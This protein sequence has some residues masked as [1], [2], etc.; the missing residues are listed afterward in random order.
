MQQRL[1]DHGNPNSF[2]FPGRTAGVHFLVSLEVRSAHVTECLP[3]NDTGANVL[4]VTGMN[5][6]QNFLWAPLPSWTEN[7]SSRINLEIISLS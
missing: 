4:H 1:P 3:V 2:L 5:A 7:T 6:P